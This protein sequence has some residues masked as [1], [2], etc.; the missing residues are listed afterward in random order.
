MHVLSNKVCLAKHV[1]CFNSI[2]CSNIS[3]VMFNWHN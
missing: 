3:K 2:S 1:K